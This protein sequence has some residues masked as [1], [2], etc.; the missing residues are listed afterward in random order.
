MLVSIAQ[1]PHR[2]HHGSQSSIA[3][4]SKSKQL[5]SCHSQYCFG[6]KKVCYTKGWHPKL[7]QLAKGCSI[8][9]WSIH[10][11]SIA[12]WK[13]AWFLLILCTRLRRD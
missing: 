7:S 8:V 3:V 12:K 2:H 9:A 6:L 13:V 11:K 10:G 1:A 5:G 4:Y